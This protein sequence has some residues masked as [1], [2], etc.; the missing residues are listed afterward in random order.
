[1]NVS[2][3]LLIC[4]IRV[5]PWLIFLFIFMAAS[6]LPLH[7]QEV[8][9][10]QTAQSARNTTAKTGA[11]FKR[12]NTNSSAEA[13]NSRQV[14]SRH[15]SANQTTSQ[16]YAFPTKRQR[17]KR[18][19]SSIAG[20][21]SLLRTG[22]SAGIEQWRDHPVEWGQG[23]TGFGKRYVSGLGRNAIQQ[24]VTYGLDQALGLD[25]GFERS[26]RKGF[27]PRLTDALAQNITSRTKTGKR[28]ISVPR[29]ASAYAGGIIP[30][31][32]WYPSRYNYK[33]G[34]RSGTRSL[35]TGFG[36]NL[37]REFVIRW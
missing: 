11:D 18:Y 34:L 12:R 2:G 19:V 33:D 8:K 3:L 29:L 28:V 35:V 24:T 20:P 25:T 32:T 21:V 17:T 14:Q 31:E 10:S 30:A 16:S 37:A 9:T 4:V 26:K 5:N 36:I 13:E 7:S 27:F 23:A 15:K 1:M 6:V 22:V